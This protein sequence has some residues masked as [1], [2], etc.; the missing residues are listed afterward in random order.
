MSYKLALNV[1]V[2]FTGQAVVP[3]HKHYTVLW[4]LSISATKQS[5]WN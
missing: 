1:L 5:H 3:I 2:T 4:I